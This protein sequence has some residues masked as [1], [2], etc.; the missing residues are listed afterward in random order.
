MVENAA[1]RYD[2]ANALHL[3]AHLRSS[4]ITGGFSS[5]SKVFRLMLQSAL[6]G[7][8]AY[9]ALNGQLT[10]GAIIA[11]SIAASR[12]LAPVELAIAHWKSFVAARHSAGS[13]FKSIKRVP[14][15]AQPLE[16]PAPHGCLEL[17]DVSIAAPITGRPI[18]TDVSFKL[19]AGQGLGVIGPSAVGKSTL[20]RAITNVWPLSDGRVRLD[21]A[22]IEH[23]SR[24][25]LG[26]F[27][28]YLPQQVELFEGTIAQN[29]ARLDASPEAETVIAAARAAGAHEMIL[30][31]PDGYETQIDPRS[32]ALSAG[33][34]QRVGLARAL[35][36]NPFLVVLDEPNSNLDA[37]GE[38]ALTTA[39]RSV[40]ERKGIVIVNTH[41]P[42]AL[43]AVDQVAVLQNGK[44]AAYG[45][46]EQL[47]RSA[48][49]PKL[50]SAA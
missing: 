11:A 33:Q 44:L 25:R 37:D 24:E 7:V 15:H 30:S 17:E 28:G 16:L 1:T 22:S 47:L 48:P 42:S 5:A 27:V 45:P 40:L 2:R 6:L 38:A 31:Q 21:G 26:R 8:G 36:G 41:R 4:D 35:Y 43:A 46:K 19:E 50:A 29:I 13:L 12:A 10:A 20:A 49:K 23:W 9:L 14:A 32:S 34:R 39:I 3:N 18:L